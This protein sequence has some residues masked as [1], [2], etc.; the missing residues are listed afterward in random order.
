MVAVLLASALAANAQAAKPAAVKPGGAGGTVTGKVN[1]KGTAPK[2]RPLNLD[3]DPACAATHSGPATPEVVVVNGNGTLKNVFVY[4]KKGLEGKTFNPPSA[5]VILDQKGCVYVPHVLGLQAKQNLKITT[6]D[7][8]THNIHPLPQ[9]NTEW[10]VSQPAG[11]APIVKTFAKPEVSIPVVC[12]QHPWM[13]AYVH[14]LS[15]PFFAVT[16]EN[17]NFEIKGLPPGKY[18]IEAVHERYGAQTQQITVTA[19]KGATT[20]FNYN[21]QQAYAPSSLKMMPAI[22][23]H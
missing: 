17:G 6:S 21:A 16:D 8:T 7:K 10:N 15:H 9:A 18:E 12:N 2:M 23:V 4:V 1:F 22:V 13:R 3:A 5:P 11:S 19:A 14:V 20:E